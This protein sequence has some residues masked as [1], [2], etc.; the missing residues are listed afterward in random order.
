[1]QNLYSDDVGTY[2]TS[3][4]D[5]GCTGSFAWCAVRKI[6]Y[7]PKW[8]QRHP[9]NS[10]QAQCVSISVTA[11]TA[12]LETADCAIANNFICEVFL[13]LFMRP[14]CLSS[15]FSSNHSHVFYKNLVE[16]ENL[17]NISNSKY[18][19][20]PMKCPLLCTKKALI[21]FILRL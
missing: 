1:M 20:L 17:G 19:A 21:F 11:S 13:F 8:A 3:G 18:L 4:T 7:K 12:Q 16:H 9:V 6:L 14:K 10:T 2:W 15:Q 5:Q